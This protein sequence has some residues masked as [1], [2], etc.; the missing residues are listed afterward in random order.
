[1]AVSLN[2]IVAILQIKLLLLGWCMHSTKW[3]I[4]NEIIFKNCCNLTG[5]TWLG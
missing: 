4:G 3:G 5:L 2:N 1:M